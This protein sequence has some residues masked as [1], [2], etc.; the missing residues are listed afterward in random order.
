MSAIHHP[1]NTICLQFERV[2]FSYNS[3]KTLSDVSFHIHEGEFVALVGSNGAGKTT[4]LKLMLGLEKPESGMIKL[5]GESAVDNRTHAKIGYVPQSAAYDRA[6]PVSVEGV[7][8]MGR[9]KP[10]S[11]KWTSEDAAAVKDALELSGLTAL[12]D[13]PYSA[14]SGGERRRVLV[15]RALSAKPCLLILDEPTANMDEESEKRLFHTL[16]RLKENTTIL[17]V[18]HD[19]DFVSSLV[20]RVLCLEKGRIV[21]HEAEAVDD[22]N[23]RVLH[24]V[25]ISG[26]DC[27]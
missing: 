23:L 13:R 15:A 10:F 14:L 27:L 9:L 25:T 19:R 26:D 18:T 24:S 7:A 3:E 22:D 6:F 11:R 2:S 21:Q 5:F 20:D 4:A 1:P 12:A 16:K 17:I 8:R